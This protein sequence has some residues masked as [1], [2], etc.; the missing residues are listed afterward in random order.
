VNEPVSTLMKE[1]RRERTI[2]TLYQTIEKSE[3]TAEFSCPSSEVEKD[4]SSIRRVRGAQAAYKIRH[5]RHAN[6]NA[7]SKSQI[8]QTTDVDDVPQSLYRYFKQLRPADK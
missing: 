8:D 5:Q 4:G 3:L 2:F 7:N 6:A 1:K